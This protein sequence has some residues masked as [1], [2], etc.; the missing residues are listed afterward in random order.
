MEY[1]YKGNLLSI[2]AWKEDYGWTWSSSYLLEK[3]IVFGEKALTPRKILN[4]LRKWGFLNHHSKGR[5][6]VVEQWPIIE[7][8][9]RNG[10]PFLALQFD[11]NPLFVEA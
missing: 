4:A 5:V 9:S 1:F 11:T 7:I 2:E 3:D 6:Q 8:Q 10:H